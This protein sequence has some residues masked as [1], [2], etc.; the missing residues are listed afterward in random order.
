MSIVV[1]GASG[2]VGAT[3]VRD[4]IGRGEQVRVLLHGDT[5]APLLSGLD[6]QVCR[7]D[8][9]DPA[10]LRA[11]FQGADTVYHLAAMISVNGDADGRVRAV[12][13]DGA[14]NAAT[15]A[16]EC[17][18]RRYVHMSSVHAFD[19]HPY[20]APLDETRRR[21]G[22]NHPAYDRSKA[23]GEAA[24]REVVAR[25]LAAV[26]VN[27]SGILGPLDHAPSHMGA[28][29]LKIAHREIP[30]VPGGGFDWV[31]VRDVSRSTIAAAERGRPGESYLLPGTWA[32]L[33]DL[34]RHTGA[35]LGVRTPRIAIPLPVLAFG[36]AASSYAAALVG[37]RPL[38]TRDSLHALRSNR[39]I[40][41]EKAARELGH[42]VRP[43]ETTLRDTYTWMADA[44]LLRG[45]RPVRSER[46]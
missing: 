3:L 38:Y 18:V 35:I 26:I 15:A 13:V 17:G 41:G 29:L 44:G 28:A 9:L 31:D 23:A 20:D 32:S 16:L 46:S 25:G 2:H 8:V 30:A 19:H 22:D 21:P 24:V 27:P 12:N 11:A 45:V 7:G 4:L 1:T 43:L 34:S 39:V 5:A 40:R 10:S 42:T 33:A 36:A 6:V 37:R 14:R